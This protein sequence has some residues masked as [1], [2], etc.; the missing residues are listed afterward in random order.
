M[1]RPPTLG[2]MAQP[3]PPVAPRP[4]RS[5]TA[6]V[7]AVILAMVVGL[8]GLGLVGFAAV[9]YFRG[10]GGGDSAG[11]SQA[12]PSQSATVPMP[13]A[14]PSLARFYKQRLKWRACGGNDCARLVVPLDYAT[15]SGRV[16]RLSVL[17]VRAS[18]R[19]QR[20]GALVVNPGG[21]GGSGVQYAAAGALVFGQELTRYFDIVG[22]D[23]R[24]VG[25]ST[26]LKCMDTQQ[27]DEL[28]A[29]DPDPDNPAEVRDLDRLTK[30]FGDGCLRESGEL[31]RHVSTVE[32]AKDIDILRAALG[33]RQLDYFGA[34]YGTFL[35]ATYADLFPGHVRRMVLDGAI[36][37][38]L[39][40]K[41]LSLGQAHGFEVALRAY[42]GDCVSRGGCILGNTV[43]AGAKRVRRLLDEID[44]AP[45]DTGTDR[46]L[47]EGLATL[48]VW[49]PLYVKEYWPELTDALTS[50]IDHGDGGALLRLADQYTSRGPDR[51]TDN[52]LEAL[53]AVNCLDHDDFIDSA[54][55]PSHF[56]EFEKASPTFGRAFAYSLS[57]CAS[58][59]VQ[60]GN[61]STALTAA[62]APPIV[63]VG[64]TR[65]PAT[66]YAWAK[67]LARQLESG[68]LISRD[69]DGHTGFQQGNQCVD[70]AIERYLIRGRAPKDNLSC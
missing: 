19:G 22:F 62:G 55:V 1:A 66:P 38:S 57:T 6:I 45:L 63:V 34:S 67:A 14:P 18:Q 35:G 15:P 36:D 31:A 46:V 2:A 17:R 40:T 32:A 65:D 3:Y 21:P 49:L 48:G 44:G 50:A 53:Y 9:A 52:S 54:Q 58:W 42:V 28:V 61:R 41:E 11:P 4:G 60:S 51:Y 33:E 16:I 7:V 39:S 43:D 69:G 29:A 56:A 5:T 8:V 25:Q 37:P 30:E 70:D 64:T 12:P 13:T 47:T 10:N 20:V 59:P 26:P 68:R 27:T 24:G 23:P